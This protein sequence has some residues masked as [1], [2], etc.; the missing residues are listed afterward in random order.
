MERVL[1]SMVL[2]GF[3]AATAG[4]SAAAYLNDSITSEENIFQAGTVSLEVGYTT[5]YNDEEIDDQELTDNP[6]TIF[7]FR[8]VKPGDTGVTTINIHVFDNDAWTWMLFNET[9]TDGE[10]AENIQLDIWYDPEGDGQ[11]NG[12]DQIIYQ[13]SLEDLEN[14]E[15]GEGIILDGDIETED[16]E[17]FTA[18]EDNYISVRWSIAETVQNVDRDFKTFDLEFFAEQERHNPEPENPWE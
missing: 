15:L 16:E 14:S 12:E 4:T 18:S 7:D 9:G 17:A 6:G 13:G 8:D 1:I 5:V 2:I 10:L 3:V 11:I